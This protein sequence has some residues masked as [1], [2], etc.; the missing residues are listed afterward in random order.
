MYNTTF[1][2]QLKTKASVIFDATKNFEAVQQLLGHI[3]PYLGIEHA[4]A[5][6]IA[7]NLLVKSSEYN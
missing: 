6:R 4:R 5:L 3:G 2:V 1:F 7:E